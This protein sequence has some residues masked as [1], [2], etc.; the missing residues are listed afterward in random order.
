MV[1]PRCTGSLRRG[2]VCR[3][4]RRRTSYSNTLHSYQSRRTVNGS[5]QSV[6][7]VTDVLGFRAPRV[8]AMVVAAT[9]FARVL[10]VHTTRPS[11]WASAELSHQSPKRK[12]ASSR[13]TARLIAGGAKVA[14][15]SLRDWGIPTNNQEL[16]SWCCSQA[17]SSVDVEF[18]VFVP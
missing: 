18:W 10:A 8:P 6:P 11:D 2:G 3:G 4:R 13:G 7:S 15:H 9:G 5:S 12:E 14:L 1:V 16:V 17:P